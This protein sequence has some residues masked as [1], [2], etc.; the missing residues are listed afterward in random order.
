MSG[1]ARPPPPEQSAWGDA[2]TEPGDRVGPY[3]LVRPLGAGGMG[4][5]FLAWDDRLARPVAIKQVRREVAPDP[6][7]RERLR[8]EARAAARL[9]HPNIV[10]VYDILEAEDGGDSI[11]L[12]YVAGRSIA[13]LLQGGPLPLPLA[14]SLARQIA[15]G[16]AAAHAAGLVHRDL[17]AENVLVDEERRARILDFGLAKPLDGTDPTLT[18]HGA[19]LG[20]WRAMA[21]EQA[22]G[23]AAD[24][25]SDLFSLGVLLYE[26]LTGVSPFAGR[27]AME[28][29]R[30]LDSETPPLVTAL[31]PEI[32]PELAALVATLLEKDPAHRP[33]DAFA[34]ARNLQAI[35]ARSGIELADAAPSGSRAD[36]SLAP[37]DTPTFA[38]L[39]RRPPELRPEPEAT[40]LTGRV[41]RPQAR[42]L[43]MAL[44]A[45]LAV[46]SAGLLLVER[47]PL[48]ARPPLRVAVLRPVVAAGS[49]NDL[50]LAASGTLIAEIRFLLALEG[51]TPLEPSQIGDV[52]GSPRAV[53]RAVSA[54]EVLAATLEGAGRTA[55]VALRRVRAADGA[56]AW[57]ER[58]P[59]P[60][61]PEEALL[62]AN[63]VATALRRAYPEPRLRP[64]APD[65]DARAED[66]TRFLQIKQR[67]DDGKA[68]RE[69]ELA[70]IEALAATSPRLL[71][72]YLQAASLAVN[73]Y[74]DTKDKDYLLRA[75]A[76]L[77]RA[78]AIA[79]EYPPCLSV[80]VLLAVA[81]GRW[82]EAEERIADL[83]KL[84]PGDPIVT[85]QRCRLADARGRLDEAVGLLRQVVAQRPTWRD[86]HWLAR[87]ELRRG[88]IAP[89]RRH[90]EE[91]LR[92][93]PGNTW[94]LAT[95]AELELLHGD[96]RRAERTYLELIAAGPERSDLTNLGLVRYLL[97]DYQGA[98][99][100]Y[101]RALAIA[102]GHINVTLNLADAELAL[103]HAAAAQA[104]YQEVLRRIQAK[105]EGA[106]LDPVERTT[107]A[108]CLARL[109]RPHEAVAA[110]LEALQEHPDEAEVTFQS[111]LVFALAGED[112]SALALAKKA[113][114][115][116]VQSRWFT[117][118]G[119][120]RLRNDAWFRSLVSAPASRARSAS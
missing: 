64:G 45:L 53:A 95:L 8:R 117:T 92:L 89:A 74:R 10:Q 106:P 46:A 29:L 94:L 16:L 31:R 110:A 114:A 81:E 79:P 21:P 41:V 73:L 87:L 80:A 102:P 59:V 54:D 11:V 107:A 9:S 47:L 104:R 26:M 75:R 109:G 49:S 52:K 78:R 83:A 6:A 111:S 44:I 57:T 62:L 50:D 61:A 101:R 99:D 96:L 13:E 103:G 71:D 19:V 86:L 15:A 25:R 118:P 55:Y 84:M 33:P 67:L 56:V 115:L 116:G 40:S 35:A 43:A 72:A 108:Q 17:K 38:P 18:E 30:R 2:L 113:T 24:A 37:G 23:E 105:E 32:P 7:R 77:E 60:A 48:F 34:V 51:V 98:I 91:A 27:T 76:A 119:F 20:T 63:A 68:P 12:E 39:T 93:T 85:L 5:V 36:F 1:R 14:A 90:L 120:E 58:I 3:R 112:A 42:R 82:P 69:P 28:T 66:Y 70:R 4:E 22:R 100:S 88:E 65:L 97:G